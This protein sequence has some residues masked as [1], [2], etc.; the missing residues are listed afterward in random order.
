MLLLTLIL[1]PV[2]IFAGQNR[3]H[4]GAV[5][6]DF[7]IIFSLLVYHQIA[8]LEAGVVVLE[9]SQWPFRL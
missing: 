1:L 4:A 9:L 5:G 3:Y 6:I 2:Q 7:T 8:V